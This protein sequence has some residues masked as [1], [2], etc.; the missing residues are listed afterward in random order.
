MSDGS[1][2]NKIN[3]EEYYEVE[4]DD[5][6]NYDTGGGKVAKEHFVNHV[7][8]IGTT[9]AF[10]HYPDKPLVEKRHDFKD[11]EANGGNRFKE[12]KHGDSPYT[13][14]QGESDE[15]ARSRRYHVK[16][17][18]QHAWAGYEKYA[19]GMDELCPVSMTGNSRWGG[20]ATTLVDS[21][22]TLWLMDM[23]DE[24]FRARDWVKTK[25][26]NH[27]D[28]K[29]SV[30]ETTIRSLG[31]LLSAYDW[32]QDKAFLDQAE[33]LG[34]RLFKSFD[35]KSGI[36]YAQTNLETGESSNLSW[37]RGSTNIAEAGSLQLEFRALGRLTGVKDFKTKSEKIFR[38][39]DG[40]KPP[41]GLYPAAVRNRKAQSSFSRQRQ[42]TFGAR[43][44]SFYEYMLKIWLQGGKTEARY[45]EMYDESIQGMHDHLL[46]VS[47]PSEL[48]FI[49]D[50]VNGEM[51]YK[52]DHL[53]CFMG[54]L[55]ALG[56][57][58]DPQGLHSERAQR[59]LKTAKALTYTCY[60]M[61]AR[62]PTGISP[63]Y[64]QFH[65]GEDFSPGRDGR[66]YLL[67]P[68]TVES[69]FVL[70]HLTGDPIYREWGWEVFQ[71]IERYCKTDAGYGQLKNVRNPHRPPED[72]M[73]SFFLAETLKY[74]YLLFDPDTP[75][76]LLNKHVFNTEAHP[77]RIFPV[78][79]E[80]GVMDL[81]K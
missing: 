17:A 53:V 65:S 6:E 25:M 49:A 70:Y 73:E 1:D 52:M 48:V 28:K 37:S 19:F 51:N 5:S 47:T 39:L 35:T 74:L 43:A 58:T 27:I 57:Y 16:K 68:E 12:Y 42:I 30:F 26:N 76:D 59:D 55:L 60:Q 20:M 9:G 3:E 63:E 18:M 7:V 40:L 75:I 29:V 41:N 4:N 13:F 54:G 21:L 64:V 61:Y 36:P 67:R 38:I 8:K 71:A 11:F 31:G 81:L 69:F 46:T 44:D 2:H 23:K 80:D 14:V 66:H 15:L 50:Q 10:P 22:D 62:M 56:A 45:R 33:D 32:S 34:H 78:M 72:S 77:M 24:F 79:D